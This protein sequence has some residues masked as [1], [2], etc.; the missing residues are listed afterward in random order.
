M[1]ER[2]KPSFPPDALLLMKIHLVPPEQHR[3]PLLTP[4][5]HADPNPPR[6]KASDSDSGWGAATTAIAAARMV[7]A[8][9]NGCIST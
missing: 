5:L 1:A 9:A 4:G 3:G 8:T 7:T 6:H 2:T